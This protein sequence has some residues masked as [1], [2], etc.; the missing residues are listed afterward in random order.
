[1]VIIMMDNIEKFRWFI[2]WKRKKGYAWYIYYY[3][4]PYLKK[5]Y[6]RWIPLYSRFSIIMLNRKEHV[7]H[8]TDM[9]DKHGF[10][11]EIT[12]FE[13]PFVRIADEH[14]TP[15]TRYLS[16]LARSL[17]N[18]LA[19]HYDKYKLNIYSKERIVQ[20]PIYEVRAL[21]N[22]RGYYIRQ[23]VI[24]MIVRGYAEWFDKTRHSYKI[25]LY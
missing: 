4:K 1:M 9:F 5:V 11:Y 2:I 8:I 24:E 10:Y 15:Y 20:I 6:H 13:K 18:Y 19:Y 16:L 12:R 3:L 17:Y 23:V 22:I 7:L 21:L 25:K 14:K